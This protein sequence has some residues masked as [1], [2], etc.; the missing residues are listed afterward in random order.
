MIGTTR[1]KAA[2]LATTTAIITGMWYFSYI[3]NMLHLLG[4]PD[5]RQAAKDVA[6]PWAVLVLATAFVFTNLGLLA[7]VM[8]V[9][10]PHLA[11]LIPLIYCMIEDV[12]TSPAF[13]DLR[14]VL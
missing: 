4:G 13:R 5:R 12:H 6:L 2:D 10:L 1:E 9:V 7:A 8:V 14:A 3:L 11:L